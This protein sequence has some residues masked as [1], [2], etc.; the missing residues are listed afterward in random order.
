[1]DRRQMISTTALGAA[2]FVVGTGFAAPAC[3][4]KQNVDFYVSTITNALAS[5]KPLIPAQAQLL[6]K[7]ISIARDINEAY[8]DGKFDSAWT[9]ASNLTDVIN[10]VITNAGVGLSDTAKMIV[11]LANIALGTVLTLIKNSTPTN[12]SR[13]INP[14]EERM[15]ALVSPK[16]VDAIFQAARLQ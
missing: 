16:Q 11:S 15:R 5:L 9:L 2:G 1:M 12:A 4:G 8:Q 3:G 13:A 10:S 14:A 6:D 7:A